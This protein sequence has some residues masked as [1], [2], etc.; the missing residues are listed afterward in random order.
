[1]SGEETSNGELRVLKAL[2]QLKKGTVEE[3]REQHNALFGTTLA[4]TTVMTLLG[5]LAQKGAV[6]VDRERQPFLY[7][8]AQKQE[9]VL[10]K[11]VKSFVDTVFDG[12]ALELVLRLVE[13]EKLSPADLKSIEAKLS[14]KSQRK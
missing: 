9:S 1:M 14:A 12:H 4:Y 2:W 10:K 5:R 6:H 7:R 13:D 8:P 11:R 3:I